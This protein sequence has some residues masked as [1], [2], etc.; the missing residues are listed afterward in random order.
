MPSADAWRRVKPF[1]NVSAA[2]VRY[3]T[4]AE[5]TRLINACQGEFRHLV[6]AALETGARYSELARLKAADFDPDAGTIAIGKSKTGKGR[7]S[8]LTKRALHSSPSYVPVVAV[9]ICSSVS[10]AASRGKR[11]VELRRWL[12]RASAPA[13]RRQ[14]ISTR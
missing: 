10:Q 3:L 14:L 5:A 4:I 8:V 12:G 11:Q 2:R 1:K 9:A 13:S 6:R 7:M